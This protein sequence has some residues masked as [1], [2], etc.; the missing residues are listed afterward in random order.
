[1]LLTNYRLEACEM[2]AIGARVLLA[3][4]LALYVVFVGASSL[5]TP[6]AESIPIQSNYHVLDLSWTGVNHGWALVEVPC[7]KAQCE[8]LLVTTDGIHRSI[9]GPVPAISPCWSSYKY[10]ASKVRFANS[11]V[12]YVCDPDLLMTTD[13]GRSWKR[14]AGA[15]LALEIAIGQVVRITGSIDPCFPHCPLRI[16]T[17]DLG[18]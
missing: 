16:E 6:T 10:C 8:E 12:G 1:M 18:T 17:S 13:A 11:H 3:S 5:A 9:A 15:T 4:S 7:G 2:A 14:L